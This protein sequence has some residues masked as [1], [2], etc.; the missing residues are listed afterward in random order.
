MEKYGKVRKIGRG[1]FGDVILVERK[2]DNKVSNVLHKKNLIV[3]LSIVICNEE[4]A[5]WPWREGN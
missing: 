1:T 4:S 5:F 3:I 2:S